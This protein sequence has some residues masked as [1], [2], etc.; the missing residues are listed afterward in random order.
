[1][2]F[3]DECLTKNVSS[4]YMMRDEI[5][6]EMIE[7]KGKKLSTLKDK[8][9]TVEEAIMLKESGYESQENSQQEA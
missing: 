3:T 5:S 6:I 2:R 4:L 9:Q 1:M 8:L 7:A